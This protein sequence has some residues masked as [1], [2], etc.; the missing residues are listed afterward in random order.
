MEC[1]GKVKLYAC[2]SLRNKIDLVRNPPAA[3]KSSITT[4]RHLEHAVI[5]KSQTGLSAQRPRITKFSF[6]IP[7][8]KKAGESKRL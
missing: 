4:E 6:F 2:S 5:R 8:K 3:R 7:L 1:S